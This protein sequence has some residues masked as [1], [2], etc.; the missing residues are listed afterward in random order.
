[1]LSLLATSASEAAGEAATP[2]FPPFDPWHW[3]SQAFWLIVTF[4]VLYL[5]LSR[6]ILPKLSATMERRGNQIANDLDEAARMNEQAEEASRAMELEIQRARSKARETAAA[7]HDEIQ[8]EIAAETARVD[9]EVQEKLD[10]A[11]AKIATLRR[12][13]LANVEGIA[14]EAAHVMATRL[15]ASASAEDARRTVKS[16]LSEA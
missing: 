9:A 14:A 7:A 10:A 6:G 12:D 3:P 5:V 1:M 4:A 2:P 8:S 16:V 13:A 15:G 11:E